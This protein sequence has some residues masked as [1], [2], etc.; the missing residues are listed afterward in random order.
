MKRYFLTLVLCTDIMFLVAQPGSWQQKSSL[1]WN[2]FV[3]PTAR[4]A[5]VGFSIGNKGYICTGNDYASRKDLWEY[6]PA[7]DSWTQKADLGG[8]AR[9]NAIGFV[10]G[11]KGYIGLGD[12]SG[13]RPLTGLMLSDLWEYDPTANSWIQKASFPGGKRTGAAAFAINGKGYVG[14]GWGQ[15]LQ[16]DFWEYDPVTDRWT[17]KAAFGGVARECAIAFSIG[18][19]GYIGTGD[20]QDMSQQPYRDFWEYDPLAD[21]WTQKANFGG[22]FRTRA[23]GF[24]T[25]NKGYVGLGVNSTGTNFSDFWEYDAVA[26]TWVNRT[27]FA[28]MARNGA[29]G[30]CIGGEAYVVSGYDGGFG[31]SLGPISAT[32][33]NDCWKYDTHGDSWTQKASFGAA[34]R[35][36]AIGFGIGGKGYM[37]MGT[38][39]GGNQGNLT[40]F[41]EFDTLINAWSQK[42][43][44]PAGGRFW[45]VGFS[46]GGKGYAGLGRALTGYYMTDLWE[47]DPDL[48]IWKQKSSFGGTGREQLIGLSIGTKGYVGLG[49]VNGTTF[50]DFWAFDPLA[51][52]WTRVADF[53]GSGVTQNVGFHIGDKGYIGVGFG[54]GF[55]IDPTLWEYDPAANTWTQKQSKFPGSTCCY[56]GTGF[57]IGNHGYV[58]GA[59]SLTN[60]FWEYDPTADTWTKQMGFPGGNRIYPVGF[61]IGGRGYMGTGSYHA[62]FWQYSPQAD[63]R[64][65]V[66]DY[67]V[68]PSCPALSG[69]AFTWQLDNNNGLVLGINPNNNNLGA[70]CWSVRTL[71][72]GTYRNT[73]GWFGGSQAQY[74][75]YLPRNYLITPAAQP[76]SSVTVRLYCTTDELTG[77]INY[78]NTTY[79]SS[80]TQN[81]IRIIRYDGIHQDLDPTNNSNIPSDYTSI[82]PTTIGHYGVSDEYRYFEF[83]TTRF[84]E[85]YIALSS[86]TAPLAVNLLNFSADYVNGASVLHWQTAQEEN[87]SRFDVQRSTD[88]LQFIT[89]ASVSAAGHSNSIRNYNFTDMNAGALGAKTLYYRLIETYLDSMKAYSKIVVV[90]IAGTSNRISVIPS[91]AKDNVTLHLNTNT[92]NDKA[93]LVI[94]DMMG[95]KIQVRNIALNTGDNTIPLSI[96]NLS[97]GVYLIVVT[98]N[99]TKWLAK[100]E[101]Q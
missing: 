15:G 79:G 97:A 59:S 56:G 86:L 53:P 33:M 26:D 64:T 71:A 83:N 13:P 23:T 95:R 80:Y 24:S 36:S 10:I 99:D 90:K 58:G 68:A 98:S 51:N 42:A 17:Q 70:T 11:G 88:S 54:P 4:L 48:N 87:T 60:D 55:R 66:G 19:K 75:A 77:F 100:F 1:G 29:A 41:W 46:I 7:A 16:K 67:S 65:T 101:K 28:G 27:N 57:S 14:T 22:G 38:S 73:T 8:K 50:N 91:P 45:A 43:S 20:N 94:G 78:F 12:S 44:F 82:T 2:T 76:S 49:F 61:S 34:G 69:V 6:D 62:D 52:T 72:P 93:S 85:F 21:S 5:A 39:A 35:I 92:A 89:V 84:S 31:I 30:F 9:E 81:D 63:I 40:D 3:E 18:G 37:G 74:G 96:N 25:G 32:L 47:F